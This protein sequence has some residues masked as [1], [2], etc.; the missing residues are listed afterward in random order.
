MD[1]EEDEIG[2]S[3]NIIGR[4]SLINRR[5]RVEKPSFPLPFL[6]SCVISDMYHCG[7]ALHKFPPSTHLNISLNRPLPLSVNLISD[8]FT[9][10]TVQPKEGCLLV[11]EELVPVGQV[12]RV[13]T[14]VCVFSLCGTKLVGR[15]AS[16]PHLHPRHRPCKCDGRVCSQMPGNKCHPL[17]IT[18]ELGT[19]QICLHRELSTKTPDQ[20]RHEKNTLLKGTACQILAF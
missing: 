13:Y 10:R 6:N 8:M 17:L 2:T 11:L 7:G 15:A 16:N 12:V 9:P 1:T 4:S 20:N 5:A 3:N 18:G 14:C 19:D